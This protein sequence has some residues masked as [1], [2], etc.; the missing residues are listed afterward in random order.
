MSFF[1]QDFGRIR[2]QY[3][4]PADSLI[5]SENVF[6]VERSKAWQSKRNEMVREFYYFYYPE[7]D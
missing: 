2:F 5:Y 1:L 6:D 4:I 7:A 3:L